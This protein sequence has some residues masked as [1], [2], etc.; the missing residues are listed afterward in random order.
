[1]VFCFFPVGI[2][3]SMLDSLILRSITLFEKELAWDKALGP[4]QEVVVLVRW[5]HCPWAKLRAKQT[6]GSSLRAGSL[7]CLEATELKAVGGLLRNGAS[8]ADPL[9]QGGGKAGVTHSVTAHGLGLLW[10]DH[11]TSLARRCPPERS[12]Q[13]RVLVPVEAPMLAAGE[14]LG[15]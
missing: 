5:Q 1:M 6:R 9:F 15:R 10:E 12:G 14:R 13:V 11:S 8:R 7:A 3:E 2:D 4:G